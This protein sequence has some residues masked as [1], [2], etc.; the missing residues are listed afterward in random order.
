ME[1]LANK[2]WDYLAILGLFLPASLVIG[3]YMYMGIFNRLLADDYCS[4]YYARRLGLLRS[5]WYWYITWHGGFSVSAADWF[6]SFVGP[7]VLPF[8]AIITLSAWISIAVFIW[9]RV[10]F[11][12]DFTK[13]SLFYSLL[14][15][16]I[17]VFATL[18][19][20]PEITQS[21]F[22]WGGARGYFLP[23]IFATLYL[24]IYLIFI[25]SGWRP[26]QLTIWYFA[27][28]ALVFFVGGFAEVFTPVQ[29]VI[30]AVVIFW[31]WTVQKS[32]PKNATFR[33]LLAGLI[34]ALLSLVVMMS[35]PGNSLRR[36]YFPD[37]PG[38]FT[39]LSISMN[40]YIIFLKYIFGSFALVS[41][42]IGSLLAAIWAGIT[43]CSDS[44]LMPQKLWWA[45]VALI[46]GFIL[47]FGCFPAAAYGLSEFPPARTQIIPSYLLMVGVMVGGFMFGYW[48]GIHGYKS[49]KMRVILLIFA[50]AFILISSWNETQFLV[51]IHQDHVSFAQK[52]DRVDAKIKS[53]GLSGADDVYIPSMENWAGLEYPK[54][55]A[56]F[57]VNICFSQYYGIKVFAPPVGD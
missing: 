35:A 13:E 28:F 4:I 31:V 53:A 19:I 54:N 1:K 42:V 33:F 18:V 8:M 56:K 11:P 34:G 55:R 20:S 57:W 26:W 49:D 14:L 45:F 36:E 10:F 47:A 30:F 21:F 41:C 22:W 6:L 37:P 16:V 32:T 43:S 27:S 24:L 2:H 17:L 44:R 50:S 51:S 48:L 12:G 52:W 5:I 39:I 40:G 9:R 25:S 23:L 38:L 3:F 46:I 29:L 7:G 15:G